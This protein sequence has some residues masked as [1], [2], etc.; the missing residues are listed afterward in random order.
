RPCSTRIKV[1][2]PHHRR[3][4]KNAAVL[5]IIAFGLLSLSP[6]HRE[7]LAFDYDDV[8]PGP[9]GLGFLV[10]PHR[11]LRDVRSHRAVGQLQHYVFSP[12]TA[13]LPIFQREIARIGD[14]I[15]VP[16][17]A[18]IGFTFTAEIFRIAKIRR[19]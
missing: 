6:E 2:V 9:M 13:L 1:L 18:G 17:A 12:S 4:S 15:G 8:E 14:K 5:P 19:A 10:S 3:W 7:A 16:N 11:K